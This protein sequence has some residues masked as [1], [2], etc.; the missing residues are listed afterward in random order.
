MME[1]KTT[2]FLFKTYHILL[3]KFSTINKS[4]REKSIDLS[5]MLNVLPTSSW[6][7][8]SVVFFKSLRELLP[9]KLY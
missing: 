4:T 9:I 7:T 3:Q 2:F 1:E 5:E 6:I 8:S